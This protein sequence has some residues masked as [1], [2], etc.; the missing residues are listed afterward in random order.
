MREPKARLSL[1]D[2][3]ITRRPASRHDVRI[4]RVQ[5]LYYR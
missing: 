1:L 3:G 2:L 4:S 5:D